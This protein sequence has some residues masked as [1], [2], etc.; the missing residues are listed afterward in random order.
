[1]KTKKLVFLIL[2]LILILL[3]VILIITRIKKD[4]ETGVDEKSSVYELVTYEERTISIEE[5]L[6]E[7]FD[8]LETKVEVFIARETEKHISG[9]FFIEN[10]PERFFLAVIDQ[11][12][13]VV[14][15]GEEEIDCSVVDSYDFPKEMAPN[16]F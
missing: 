7:M 2:G 10:E 3:I 16:C 12:I 11:D 4:A 6:A 8:T 9:I 15:V 1:M 13:E 14:W 5:A